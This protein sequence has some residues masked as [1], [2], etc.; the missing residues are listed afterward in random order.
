M[1]VIC[2]VMMFKLEE[3]RSW[4][5]K[6][7][8]KTELTVTGFEMQVPRRGTAMLGLRDDPPTH[9]VLYSTRPIV[10]RNKLYPEQLEPVNVKSFMIYPCNCCNSCRSN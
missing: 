2:L 5:R 8:C 9:N 7:Q 1:L 6:W 3:E 10:R 4:S